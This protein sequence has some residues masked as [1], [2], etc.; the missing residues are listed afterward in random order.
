MP[1]LKDPKLVV[2]DI[3]WS[4]RSVMRG[5]AG[6][7]RI[8]LSIT[9]MPRLHCSVAG[10]MRK[11]GEAQMRG[12]EKIENIFWGQILRLF[13]MMYGICGSGESN[14]ARSLGEL[15][16]DIDFLLGAGLLERERHDFLKKCA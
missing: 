11:R 10:Q 7:S 14:H 2:V 3:Y 5:L 12:K 4:N 8:G 6:F 13:G 16:T 1:G 9:E 15:G